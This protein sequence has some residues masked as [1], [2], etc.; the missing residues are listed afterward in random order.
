MY[1]SISFISIV[2][3]IILLIMMVMIVMS[4]DNE[5]YDERQLIIRHN[6]YKHAFFSMIIYSAS[7]AMFAVN[8]KKPFLADGASLLIG[9]YIGFT[10]FAC[11]CIWNGVF[12]GKNQK[13]S[14]HGWIIL[15]IF[16]SQLINTVTSIM[17]GT[18]IKNGVLTTESMHLFS[19]ISFSLVFI[20]F[21]IRKFIVKREEE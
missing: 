20:T 14:T 6:A 10:V 16:L 1:E 13:S 2:L 21:L 8:F 4:R 19:S 15:I 3:I 11:E 18:T 17:K 7:Y 5:E 12:F 9:M